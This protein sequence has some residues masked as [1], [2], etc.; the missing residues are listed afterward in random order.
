M[1]EGDLADLERST[2]KVQWAPADGTE[3]TE[4]Y[5][6]FSRSGFSEDLGQTASERNDVSLFTPEA[7]VTSCEAPSTLSNMFSEK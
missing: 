2:A 6:C 3:R 4:H 7:I 5:H 1:T